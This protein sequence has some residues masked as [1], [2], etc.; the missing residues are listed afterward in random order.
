M[1]LT[2]SLPQPTP[3]SREC[4]FPDDSP[5]PAPFRALAQEKGGEDQAMRRI[6]LL[7]T[8]AAVMLA[9]SVTPAFAS[10]QG[11]HFIHEPCAT[12]MG[13]TASGNANIPCGH[14]TAI[15]PMPPMGAE[16]SDSSYAPQRTVEGET[17]TP[18]PRLLGI[19]E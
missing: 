10:H 19:G 14:L 15:P 4:P 5:A 2:P 9:M 3:S 13:R 18:T 16:A 6:V 8:V 17:G 12:V 11:N 7:V 1:G